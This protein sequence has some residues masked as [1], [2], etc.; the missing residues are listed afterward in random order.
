MTL[1]AS[2]YISLADNPSSR[3]YPDNRVVNIELGN[4]ANTTIVHPSTPVRSLTGVSSGAVRLPDDYWGKSYTFVF[5]LPGGY[6]I[7]F[8][9]QALAAGWNGVS[10]VIG[11]LPY[12]N[13]IL[14]NSVGTA[15]LTISG[16]FPRGIKFINQ[17]TIYGRGGNG[18]AGSNGYSAGASGQNAGTALYVSV[19]CQVDNALGEL[20]GGGGGGGG[21]GGNYYKGPNVWGGGGGG[22]G[23]YNAGGGGGGGG[24]G[25]TAGSAGTNGGSGG[26]GGAGSTGGY[27]GGSGGSQG[28]GGS[29]GSTSGNLAAGS[30]GAAGSATQGS[31]S[32]ITWV[33]AGYGTRIGPIN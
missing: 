22:G 9:T 8:R 12:G 17:S 19:A 1:A 23:G 27:A 20:R 11:T 32:Y 26:S 14:S 29:N 28:S 7:D 30:G 33:G 4:A 5:N 3:A 10:Y 6:N 24:G 25:A 21:G 18:G 2:G 13:V 15:G 31:A 16:S